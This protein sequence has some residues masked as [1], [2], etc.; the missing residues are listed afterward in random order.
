MCLHHLLFNPFS[1]AFMRGS[2]IS[3]HASLNVLGFLCYRVFWVCRMASGILVEYCF[4]NGAW[5]I[6]TDGIILKGLLAPGRLLSNS[7]LL[8]NCL[9]SREPSLGDLYDISSLFMILDKFKVPLPGS[10]YGS[11]YK[12]AFTIRHKY[13]VCL[14][15]EWFNMGH[16]RASPSF[17]YLMC[18]EIAAHRSEV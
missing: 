6:V 13:Q 15:M 1:W 8:M 11:N 4:C 17:F 9:Q 3:C 5:W 10:N 14:W 12:S 7:Q 16:I 18:L 2:F